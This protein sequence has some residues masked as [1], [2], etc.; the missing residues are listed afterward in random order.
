MTAA[1]QAPPVLSNPVEA[2][3][4]GANRNLGAT[5]GVAR[6][7]GSRSLR[8]GGLQPFTS[9]DY[10]GALA[11]VVFVQGCPWRC[12]YCHNP[13]LQ[14]R[15]PLPTGTAPSWPDLLHWLGSR[16]GLLDAVVF[17]GGEPTADAA[18]P[19]AIDQVRAL[20]FRVGLHT[21]GMLP[22]RLRALL[23]RLDWVGLD[24]KAPLTDGALHAHISGTRGG[25]KG[26][27]AAVRESLAALCASGIAFE[28]RTTA[29]PALLDGPALEAIAREL[30]AFGVTRYAVQ[31]SRPAG[32]LAD[33]AVPG[34]DYPPASTL[35]RL[36]ASLPQ[37]QLRRATGG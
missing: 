20:G 16:R 36:R 30:V 6:C 13:Q 7:D 12:L 14:S 32:A 35:H 19:Q 1:L 21:A 25:A 3:P 28:C 31:V 2:G 27:A 34:A 5:R 15:R 26:G 37:F 29:H 23:P 33:A 17:S 11:A 4:E 22:R 9:I 18:L 24:I 8:V 10:P